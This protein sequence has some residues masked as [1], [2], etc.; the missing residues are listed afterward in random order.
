MRHIW[1]IFC[2]IFEIPDPDLSDHFATFMI[3]LN[4]VICQSMYGPLQLAA[5]APNHVTCK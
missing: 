1:S 3:K 4:R 2:H 5:H